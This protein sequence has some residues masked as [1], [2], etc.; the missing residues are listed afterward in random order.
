VRVV[1]RTVAF[2]DGREKA[3][4]LDA[5]ASLDARLPLVREFGGR[6]AK[7]HDSNDVEAMVRDIFHFVRDVIHYVHDPTF[8]EF[9]DTATILTRGFDDC[10]GKARTFVALCRAIGIE[11]R[12][13]PVFNAAGD[14]VHVQAEARWRGSEHVKNAQ[15]GGWILAE[16]TIKGCELGQD[17]ATAPRGTDGHLLLT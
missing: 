2:R 8:E 17:P 9:A 3:A 7:A 6:F 10:D 11:A 14:F 12:I 5:M 16:T 1:R 13:R 15:P 4:Y